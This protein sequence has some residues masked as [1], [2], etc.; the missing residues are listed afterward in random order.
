MWAG[1]APCQD[2]SRPGLADALFKFLSGPSPRECSDCGYKTAYIAKT[3][4]VV[5]LLS[6]HR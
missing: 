2:V 6:S 4:E 3:K 5:F 1:T